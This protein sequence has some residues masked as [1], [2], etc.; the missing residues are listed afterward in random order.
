MK[1]YAVYFVPPGDL[2]LFHQI[3]K[4]VQ[5]LPDVDLGVNE[6][7]QKVLI[8][9]HMVARALARFFPAVRCRDGYFGNTHKHSWLVTRS[10]LVIDVYPIAV[11]GGPILVDIRFISP[12]GSLYQEANLP[13]LKGVRF[14]KNLDKLVEAVRQTMAAL[15]IQGRSNPLQ[16]NAGR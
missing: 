2:A 4:I 7:G 9:C 6:K 12:W 14:R 11:T 8:S 10:S 3:E 15:G 1:P 13:G 16:R 5:E